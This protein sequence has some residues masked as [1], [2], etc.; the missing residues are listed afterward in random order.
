AP[1]RHTNSRCR[2][3]V[4]IRASASMSPSPTGNRLVTPRITTWG[5]L[6]SGM[7]LRTPSQDAIADH[8][9]DSVRENSAN[10]NHDHAGHHQVSARERAAVH[11]HRAEPGG[12]T[13][14]LAH[15]DQDPGKSVRDA[16]PIENRG[17]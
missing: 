10:S 7:V 15:H 6:A 2:I 16:K 8:N 11:D 13:G 9:Y 4:S 12:N 1:I 17:Q 3:T 5:R 14:H